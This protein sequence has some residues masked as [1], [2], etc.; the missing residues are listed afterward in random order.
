VNQLSAAGRRLAPPPLEDLP[1]ETRPTDAQLLAAF[2]RDR[3]EAAFAALVARHGPLV[4][5]VCRRTLGHPHDA[6]DAFQVAFLVLARKAATLRAAD[7]LAPWLHGVAYRAAL[8]IRAARRR[9]AREQAMNPL[10]EPAVSA[11]DADL[12]EIAALLDREIARLPEKLR[13]AVVLCE[14]QGRPRREAARELG[15]PEGT[16]SSRLAD[17][18]Q[19]LARR[20]RRWGLAVTAALLA[21]LMDRARAAAPVPA[22]LA[23]AAVQGGARVAGPWAVADPHLLAAAERVEKALAWQGIPRTTVAV[24]LTLL[25][26]LLSWTGLEPRQGQPGA[27]PIPA[28]RFLWA[29]AAAPDGKAL[30]V[31]EG[32]GV[33]RL[34]DLASRK[35]G[36]ALPGPTQSIRSLAFAPDG[37]TLAAGGDE[38]TVFLWD[39]PAGH[40]RRTLAG[41]RGG[42]HTVAFAPDG[43]ALAA[44]SHVFP[45]PQSDVRLWDVGPGKERWRGD[46]KDG[47]IPYGGGNVLA[48]APDGKE[49]ALIQTG[50]FTGIKLLDVATGRE[51][52]RLPYDRDRPDTLAFSP[53]GRWLL[54][55][56]VGTAKEVRPGLFDA[57]RGHVKVWERATG[58]LHRALL[59]GTDGFVKAVAF[60]PDG[61]QCY[62]ATTVNL[63]AQAQPNG[64]LVGRLVSAVHCWET[65]TWQPRWEARGEGGMVFGLA[66]TPDGRQLAVAD[67]AGLW[68]VADTAMGRPRVEL[69]THEGR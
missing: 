3:D 25:A 44:A 7:R 22:P 10:P 46:G 5:G 18:R 61:K 67:S 13:A 56:G 15:I 38:G 14:L 55:G 45:E 17:A 28:A 4:L 29:V 9:H 49:L 60:S 1:T 21:A 53:D 63:G 43:Q 26:L 65:A 23:R 50:P 69:A 30:A 16:L 12:A 68:L 20:L 40:L 27:G 47:A 6:E 36:P 39:V 59:E 66:P 19:R 8:E 37:R 32:N 34:W 62:A 48:F 42:L 51:R 31:S 57:P 11:P 58:K 41:H 24:F 2:V 33:V 64:A 35:P 54:T 52:Q